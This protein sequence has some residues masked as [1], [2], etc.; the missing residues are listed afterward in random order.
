MKNCSLCLAPSGQTAKVQGAV[1]EIFGLFIHCPTDNA[2]IYSDPQ[3]LLCVRQAIHLNA[4][5]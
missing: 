5:T 4:A 2:Y 1:L 3:D